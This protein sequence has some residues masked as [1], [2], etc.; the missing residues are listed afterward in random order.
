MSYYTRV[1]SQ[2]ADCPRFDQLVGA[3]TERNPGAAL[4][5]EEGDADTWTSLLLAHAD[6]TEIAVIERNPVAEGALGMEEVV[7]F[8]DEIAD[9]KPNSAVP[10]LTSFLR[11]VKVIYA[12]QHLHGS[13]NT[14]GAGALRSISNFIWRRGD[15]IL[16]ADAEGFSNDEGYHILWQF[17]DHV[18]GPWWMAVRNGD[19]WLSFQ[20]DLANQAHRQAFMDGKIP[21]GVAAD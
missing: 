12:F 1:L 17:S 5:I 15:A 2:R 21:D 16:Q 20:M 10:W 3:L 14:E 13:N 8:I 11:S 7:E 18:S 9:C 6:G 19:G 4:S